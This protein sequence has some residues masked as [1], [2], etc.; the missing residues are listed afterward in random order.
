[1]LDPE[2]LPNAQIAL[3]PAARLLRLATPAA[4]IWASYQDGAE[5]VPHPEQDEDVLVTR[6]EADVSVRILPACGYAF[7][8][9]LQE[10]ATLAEAVETLPHPDEFGSHLVG[11]VA[12]GAV[13]SIVPGERS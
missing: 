2:A 13:R 11:L 8:K 9:R 1:M 6:P 7:A 5:P 3:H 4:S 12:A 10:G